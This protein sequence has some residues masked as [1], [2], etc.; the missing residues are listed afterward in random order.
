MYRFWILAGVVLLE[1]ALRVGL[2]WFN[3]SAS[4][5]C[6]TKHDTDLI[7]SEGETR[8]LMGSEN[9]EVMIEA[10]PETFAERAAI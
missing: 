9:P 6:S 1:A 5:Y 2:C 4:P 8:S 3:S 7:E 10:K